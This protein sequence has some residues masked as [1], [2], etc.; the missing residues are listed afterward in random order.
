MSAIEL[1]PAA[2]LIQP[3]WLVHPEW[4]TAVIGVIALGALAL[5]WAGWSSRHR[6]R[7][8]LG[9]VAKLE[10]GN[11]ARDVALL[12][13]LIAIGLALLGPRLGK[14]VILVP[15]TGIDV[16][17][18]VDV[19]RSMD[20]RDVPPSR[21][22][23]ARRAAQE[24]LARLGSEDRAGL[25]VFGSRGLLLA[26]LTPDRGALVEFLSSLDTG[27]VTPAGSNLG[28]GIEAA[29]T[30]F[31]PASERPGI[32]FVLSDGEDPERGRDLGVARATAAGVR[33]LAAALGS[34]LGAEIPDHGVPLRDGYGQ[35]ILTRRDRT[36]LERLANATDGE[37]FAG[38]RW[39]DFD[40][41]RAAA[42]IRR[43]A[44]ASHG[45]P[46]PR[47][48]DAVRVAPLVAVA[49][50]LLLAE[51]LPRPMLSRP[52][53]WLRPRPAVA[54][55][56]LMAVTLLTAAAPAPRASGETATLIEIV[57][58]NAEV[59]RSNRLGANL[60]NAYQ[61]LALGLAR[62]EEREPESAARAFVAAAVFAREP[63]L[64]ALAYYNLGVAALE[65]RDLET[66]RDA[67]FDSLALAPGDSQARFNLEWTLLGLAVRPPPSP[68]EPRPE[69]ESGRSTSPADESPPETTEPDL[70]PATS[71]VAGP[72]PSEAERARL[73]GRV[74]DDPTRGFR[75][76]RDRNKYR[77][78]S[79]LA[80]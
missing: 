52:K 11:R 69:E 77:R 64:A 15:A 9:P 27:L 29:L 17:F 47:R 48:V 1:V 35:T 24:L 36:R 70:V 50:L 60:D 34:D 23:R 6:R 73:L 26:P 8:L 4:V 65:Q 67:F 63:E 2:W 14:R 28:A 51:M 7:V 61:W 5:G 75:S 10:V 57:N 72:T 54:A 19:S 18:L 53:S 21:L 79:G 71:D 12:V 3:T 38:D 74:I 68:P 45:A 62:L 66:A 58:R 20:A 31:A 30:A 22:D 80:W 46:V 39:G 32:V 78:P 55:A 37:V 42:S 56:S 44:A 16:V 13:A 59:K 41:A 76:G 49:F 25:A 43:D 33:V 40:F